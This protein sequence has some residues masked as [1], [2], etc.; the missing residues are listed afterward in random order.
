MSTKEELIKIAHDKK[1]ER[2]NKA[3]HESD[4]MKRLASLHFH[5]EYEAAMNEYDDEIAKIEKMP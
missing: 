5:N 3:V 4:E 1:W 2:I